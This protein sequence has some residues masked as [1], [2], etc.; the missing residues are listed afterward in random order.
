MAGDDQQ[1]RGADEFVLREPPVVLVAY[2]DQG[3]EQVVAGGAPLVLDEAAQQGVQARQRGA[4]PGVGH[5]E[6]ERGPAAEVLAVFLRYAEEFRDHGDRE[7]RG[8]RLDEV[9]LARGR[10]SVEQVVGDLL[11]AWG[12]S[13]G[14]ARGEGAGDEA[15]QPGVLGRVRLQHL[16]A[17]A[18]LGPVE[19]ETGRLEGLGGRC[20]VLQK[21]RVGQCLPGQVVPDDQPAVQSR[22][23]PHGVDGAQGPQ[24]F[25]VPWCVR[26]E[27]GAEHHPAVGFG[28]S[29][30]LR[31]HTSLPVPSS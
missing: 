3:G 13:G 4:V 6:R 28:D 25:V 24:P 9:G 21:C 16:G 1:D 20:R 27:L 2:G 22:G 14:T 17:Q 30:G 11:D 10:E 19:Q 23:E 7:G 29:P 12:E 26:L 15:A 18:D 8:E 5:L 31:R